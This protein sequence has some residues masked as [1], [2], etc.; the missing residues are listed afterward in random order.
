MRVIA[1][2]FRGR[3]L[4]T[5]EG[6]STRPILD[7]VKGSLFDWLGS[8]LA[9]PGQLPPVNVCDL[10]C[11]AGSQGIEALSRGAAFCAFVET[12][13]GALKCLRS[14]IAA[15]KIA[16]RCQIVNRP[17]ESAVVTTPNGEGCS[18]VFVDPPY[19]LSEDVSP[20]GVMGRVIARIGREIP[21]RPE[22]L[23]VWRHDDSVRLPS[24]LPSGWTTIDRRTW[25][26]NAITMYAQ[27]SNE[28]MA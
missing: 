20:T 19:R 6:L 26:S 21:T 23:M 3:T 4:T 5:P 17:A 24:E 11:G 14:N 8:R 25:G 2:E 15:L 22:A 12:D 28:V 18:I 10:F 27:G 16:D 1:G 13:P 9:L 7:R